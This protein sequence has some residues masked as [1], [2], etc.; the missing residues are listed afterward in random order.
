MSTSG[1]RPA[2]IAAA[3]AAM[4]RVPLTMADELSAYGSEEWRAKR[5]PLDEQ[6]VPP[7]EAAARPGVPA[8]R[9]KSYAAWVSPKAQPSIGGGVIRTPLGMLCMANHQ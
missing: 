4:H 8:G 6:Y 1:G 7:P 5:V 9:V 3:P 2:P